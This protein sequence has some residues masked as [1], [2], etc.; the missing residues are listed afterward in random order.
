M[1]NTRAKSS[2]GKAGAPA[3]VETYLAKL[4]A[5]VRKQVLKLREAIRSAAPE[6]EEGFG[7]GMPAFQLDGKSFV[8][9]G[10]WK[11]HVSFYPVNEATRRALADEMAGYDTSG[12]G[13]IRFRSDEDLPTSLVVRIVRMRIA[14]LRK[15]A[16]A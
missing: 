10:A 12:K 4:P 7:Y 9:Y 8:W 14:E 15:K 6:A 1:A 11:S 5:G 16:K 3:E 13:T 2:K